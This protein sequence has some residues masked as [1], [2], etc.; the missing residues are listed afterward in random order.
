MSS[1]HEQDIK[2][3]SSDRVYQYLSTYKHNSTLSTY[4]ILLKVCEEA[5]GHYQWNAEFINIKYF[6]AKQYEISVI[7]SQRFC[8]CWSSSNILASID[9]H[10]LLCIVEQK[11]NSK[12]IQNFICIN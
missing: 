3:I 10:C 12:L 8:K 7:Q 6:K 4:T 11:T 1:Y 9:I 2:V 5:Y